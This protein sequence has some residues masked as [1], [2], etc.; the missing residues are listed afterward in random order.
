MA[1]LSR[2]RETGKRKE[3]LVSANPSSPELGSGSG[4]GRAGLGLRNLKSVFSNV[5]GRQFFCFRDNAYYP[6]PL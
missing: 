5:S 6:I 2:E 3:S 1:D 4:Y